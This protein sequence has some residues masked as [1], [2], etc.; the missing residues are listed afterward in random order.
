MSKEQYLT[1]WGSMISSIDIKRP[2]LARSTRCADMNP[3]DNQVGSAQDQLRAI[4]G[5]PDTDLD[6]PSEDRHD[7]CHFDTSGVL[8]LST[9]WNLYLK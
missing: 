5:G 3:Y 9:L 4:L 1:H 2:M 8:K 6:I 7:Q